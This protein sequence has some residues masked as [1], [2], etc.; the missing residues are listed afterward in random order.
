MNLGMMRIGKQVKLSA[1]CSLMK[2]N[3]KQNM[4]VSKF[5]LIMLGELKLIACCSLH[6]TQLEVSMQVIMFKFTLNELIETS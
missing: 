2:P 1:C 6:E 4:H 3:W 5:D